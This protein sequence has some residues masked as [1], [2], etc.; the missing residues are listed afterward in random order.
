[1]RWK[2]CLANLISFYDKV[3][4]L[5]DQGKSVDA[6]LIDFSNVFDTVFCGILLEKKKSPVYHYIK[7]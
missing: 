2:Y 5:A 7:T 1:M 4:R 3:T 6:F